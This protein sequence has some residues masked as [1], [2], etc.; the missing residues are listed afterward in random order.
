[1]SKNVWIAIAVAAVLLGGAYYYKT[2]MSHEHPG[3]PVMQTP[4]TPGA[5][6]PGGQMKEEMKKEHPGGEIKHDHE[7]EHPGGQMKEEMK[8]EHP[9]GGM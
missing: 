2:T 5:E 1:M 3:Q 7:K 4:A 6:H 8:K 9:G